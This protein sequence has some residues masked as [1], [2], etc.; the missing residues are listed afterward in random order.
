[1]VIDEQLSPPIIVSVA[2][3]KG[4]VG[5][6]TTVL[7]LAT[8]IA[9]SGHTVLII[10]I[11]PQGNAS[12]GIDI[13]RSGRTPGTYALLTG[14]SADG[15][16]RP[17]QVPNLWIIPASQDL[18]GAEVELA[19]EPQREFK[20]K[21]SLSKLGHYDFIVID[22]PPSLGLLTVNA[23]IASSSV[24]VPLQCEFFALEGLSQLVQ[25][26][27]YVRQALNPDLKLNGIV[28]TMHDR[29][30]NLS[31]LVAAD[32]RSF[33]GARVYD[34]VIPRNVRVSEAPSHGKP[35]LIYD[36][37]SPGAQAYARLAAEFLRRTLTTRR[38]QPHA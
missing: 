30:N 17:T 31:E 23:L 9:A 10:D 34:S 4:G 11:D 25:T 20:L 29:R 38:N 37:R 2:N 1:M 8:A 26:I 12:T 5:K 21:E 3:Q 32:A 33:F 14:E 7:N 19:H 16:I 13:P 15:L 28:L 22:C 18:V 27:E 6:T 35:V 36:V 24:L